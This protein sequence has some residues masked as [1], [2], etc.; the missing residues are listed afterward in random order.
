MGLLELLSYEFR[1][2]GDLEP[3]SVPTLDCWTQMSS[4]KFRFELLFV[5]IRYHY[6][7]ASP[8]VKRVVL[9]NETAIHMAIAS[10][11]LFPSFFLFLFH[12]HHLSSSSLPFPLSSLWYSILIK[13][14][15]DLDK[16]N[17]KYG[18]TIKDYAWNSK[19]KIAFFSFV[20]T[21]VHEAPSSEC[22]SR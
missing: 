1:R 18:K 17:R 14:T 19:I 12:R 2:R 15:F 22:E 4:S 6:L 5:Y 11:S 10:H 8:A 7:V 13:K 9:L 3:R 20:S 16:S 21:S